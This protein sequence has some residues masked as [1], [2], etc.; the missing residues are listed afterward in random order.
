MTRELIA[1]IGGACPMETSGCAMV[2]IVV[3]THLIRTKATGG[4][5]DE[6][7]PQFDARG[8]RPLLTDLA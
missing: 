2:G 5:R 6:A 7:N 3:G 4:T 8:R 1:A